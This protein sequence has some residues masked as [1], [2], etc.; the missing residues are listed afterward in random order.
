MADS[1]WEGSAFFIRW[2]KPSFTEG[3]RLV[4]RPRWLRAWDWRCAGSEL[5]D[6]KKQAGIHIMKSPLSVSSEQVW[7][8]I[9]LV[10]CTYEAVQT[11]NN[12]S[13]RDEDL[14]NWDPRMKTMFLG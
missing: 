12:I 5:K 11:C 8:F 4:R 9:G 1:Q 10:L 14:R 6:Y 2:I 3:F 7:P 13:K